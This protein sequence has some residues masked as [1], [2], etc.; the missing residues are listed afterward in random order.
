MTLILSSPVAPQAAAA[1]AA[2][3][4]G[5]SDSQNQDNSDSFGAVLERSQAGTE[6]AP[7]KTADRH[8]PRSKK[9][10]DQKTESPDPAAALVLALI[11]QEPRLAP[12]PANATP[13]GP[14]G[15]ITAAARTDIDLSATQAA[16]P[17][18]GQSD[19][20]QLAAQ[21]ALPALNQSD[22]KQLLSQ[23]ALPALNQSDPEQL[24]SATF[25]HDMPGTLPKG[26]SALAAPEQPDGD[27]P[28]L[29][30]NAAT[31]GDAGATAETPARLSA[32]QIT[33]AATGRQETAQAAQPTKNATADAG[34]AVTP[35]IGKI[36][37]QAIMPDT[38]SSGQ[39]SKQGDTATGDRDGKFSVK[40]E[41]RPADAPVAANVSSAVSSAT[42]AAATT[43]STATADQSD[44]GIAMP[45]NAA[46]Q[47]HQ[48]PVV[49][50]QQ[51]ATAPASL[52]LTPPIGSSDWGDAL[53]K[54]MVWMG[55]ANHQVAELQL[56]PAGLGPL[57]VTL[58][59]N[60]HQ[61]EAL[62]VSAHPSVRAAVEAALPQLRTSLADNGISLGNTSV[63]ADTQQQGAFAQDQA[64]QSGQ[65]RYRTDSVSAAN[66][67]ADLGLPA[68]AAPSTGN[69]NQVDTFA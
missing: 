32:P 24:A 8:Q 56:N 10:D 43:G 21:G 52:P 20:K 22:P 12:V 65:P 66:P 30:S 16:L 69:R 7:E 46:N 47:L 42:A 48:P 19:P 64:N 13:S 17:T 37:D 53:G 45:A 14:A 59:I 11:A 26:Q 49:A 15:T 6:T 5:R 4:T 67:V 33:L 40:P 29:A 3:Q 28:V 68:A 1:P 25:R 9:S 38:R 2:S 58:T 34:S 62:F 57:K 31:I 60:N 50:A 27:S 41:S 35:E 61:A 63:S 36:P 23:G 51:T 44:S 18:P 39:Q 54:Q 55:N